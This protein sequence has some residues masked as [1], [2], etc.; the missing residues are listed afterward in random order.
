MKLTTVLE[1][2]KIQHED[3]DAFLYE[4]DYRRGMTL[5]EVLVLAK[6]VEE[7][8]IFRNPKDE[9]IIE[10]YRNNCNDLSVR[11]NLEE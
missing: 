5:D 4:K 10:T 1:A 8:Y 11:V 3:F 7:E 2:I 6:E 9:N